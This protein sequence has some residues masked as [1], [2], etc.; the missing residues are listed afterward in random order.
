MR[1]VALSIR[2]KMMVMVAA[3][4]VF[5]MVGV[6]VMVLM[7]Q[8]LQHVPV[9]GDLALFVGRSGYA[10]QYM[11]LAGLVLFIV[12][13][14]IMSAGMM[15][16]LGRI[17]EA[18]N[19]I[20][21]GDLNT[22]IPVNGNDEL[23]LL[24]A[25]INEMAVRLKK[26]IEEEREAERSKDDLITS[27]SHDLRTPLT[28][29]LG[30]LELVNGA[31][32]GDEATM[33]RYVEVALEKAR[34]LSHLIDDLFEFT[35]VSHRDLAVHF[36]PVDLGM[37]LEQLAEEFVPILERAGM[38][39]RL[40]LPPEKVMVRADPAL[41]VRVFENLMSNAVR[42]G[43]EGRY[44][45]IELTASG[46]GAME[47]TGGTDGAGGTRLAGAGVAGGTGSKARAVARIANYGPRIP[48]AL[49]SRIFERFVRVE[50]SRSRDTGGAGL[51][52][53]IAKTIVD[54]HG[55]TIRAYNEDQ[56]TVF[57]VVL[58]FA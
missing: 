29:V 5:A 18:V 27:V 4:G 23:A 15:R 26:S 20:A 57:E 44:V 50:T 1:R 12:S 40:R 11:M 52:L 31:P 9:L 28:S 8:L 24:A 56:R 54:L 33:R 41:L 51:G 6:V 25:N 37:L 48:D 14:V 16:Y 55:G 49:L 35:K 21:A 42:Y 17:S 2:W 7:A 19:R 53:A 38:E 22:F 46:T 10:L 39:Y 36:E 3:S 13:F 47:G 43:A 34:S 45:D 58:D 30:Y 32:P